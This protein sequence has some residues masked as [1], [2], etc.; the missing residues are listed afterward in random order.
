MFKHNVP[1]I[2]SLLAE[3]RNMAERP[4]EML[5]ENLA[6]PAVSTFSDRYIH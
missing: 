1:C 3:D 2:R 6:L 4:I 5:L